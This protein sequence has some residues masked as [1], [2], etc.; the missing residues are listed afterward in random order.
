ML[1]G[2]A[3]ARGRTV[4][5]GDDARDRFDAGLAQRR[6]GRFD[7]ARQVILVTEGGHAH[8]DRDPLLGVVHCT[9]SLALSG[10]FLQAR[11]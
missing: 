2:D 11:S 4:T 10:A 5:D 3:L 1:V 8:S 6:V 9:P 7:R